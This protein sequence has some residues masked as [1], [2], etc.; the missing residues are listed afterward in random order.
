MDPTAAC[1]L[2]LQQVPCAG[3]AREPHFNPGRGALQT[4]VSVAL[5]RLHLGHLVLR[6]WGS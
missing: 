3:V 1:F 2:S 4:M 6:S 5:C